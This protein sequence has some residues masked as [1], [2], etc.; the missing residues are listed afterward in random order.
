MVLEFV[1]LESLGYLRHFATY[2]VIEKFHL[3][4]FISSKF[5]VIQRKTD[6]QFSF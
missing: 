3:D 6:L 5:K 4:G 1:Y 2:F